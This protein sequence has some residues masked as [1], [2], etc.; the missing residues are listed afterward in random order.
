MFTAILIPLLSKF[1][2]PSSEI[3]L[4]W[5]ES[6]EFRINQEKKTLD[7]AWLECS[8]LVTLLVF[9]DKSR[10]LVWRD[11]CSDKEYRALLRHLRWQKG[12]KKEHSTS[13]L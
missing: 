8:A 13:A 3:L 10:L 5:S 1:I 12:N 6:G 11:A 9:D 2:Q 7:R 4:A